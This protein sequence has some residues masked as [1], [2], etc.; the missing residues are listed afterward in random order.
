VAAA[1]LRQ[2]EQSPNIGIQKGGKEK[3][4]ASSL[5]CETKKELEIEIRR[6]SIVAH[7]LDPS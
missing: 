6:R 7:L 5:D 1:S 3:Q 2:Q 4:T